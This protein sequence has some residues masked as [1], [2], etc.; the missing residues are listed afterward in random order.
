MSITFENIN[1]INYSNIATTGTQFRALNINGD[2]IGNAI[3]FALDLSETKAYRLTRGILSTVTSIKEYE[4]DAKNLIDW[5]KGGNS[6]KRQ[7]VAKAIRNDGG[8]SGNLFMVHSI[9]EMTKTDARAFM[10]DY[11]NSGGT[12]K[13]VT[14]W[15]SIAGNLLRQNQGKAPNTAGFVVNAAE[16]VVDKVE[17]T[18]DSIA[19]AIEAVVDAVINAGK[20]LVEI[21]GDVISWTVEE[22][23]GLIQALLE[24]G[25]SVG[26][27]LKAAWDFGIAGVNK[28]VK[29]LIDIGKEIGDVLVYAVSQTGEILN[30]FVGALIS[31]AVSV[32]KILE[33][34]AGQILSITSKIIQT[35]VDIGR[36][37]GTILYSAFQIGVNMVGS[38]T[39]ALI[40][41]GKTVGELLIT[42]ITQPRR[43]FNEVVRALN[44][45]GQ[46]INNLF[47]EVLG[48][49]ADGVKKMTNALIE[50][51]KSIVD[52]I[53]WA[54]NK[55][56]G[57]VKDVVK[58]IID[59]G[60][61]VLEIFTNIATR[62]TDFI[63]KVVQALFNIG[64]T[65]LKLINEVIQLGVDFTRKFILAITE[66]AGGL[67]KFAKEVLR[68]TYKA[69][70]S[71]VKKL[72]DV[73]LSVIEILGTIV[74][75]SYW[76]F[77][78]IVSGIIQHLVPVGDLLDWV[79][80]QAENTVSDLW[81]D[82]LLAIRYAKGK[83][84][85][86]IEWAV[87]KSDHTLESVL[88]AWESIEED[89]IDFYV[90]AARLA[91]SGIDRVF[92][93]IGKATIKLENSVTYVL[94]FL[95]KDFVPG[96]KDFIQGVLDAGYEITSLFVNI[97]HLSLQAFTEVI[98]A[99]LDYGITLTEL[100]TETMKNPS[101]L[102]SNFLQAVEQAGQTLNDVYQSVII[103]TGEQFIDEVTI[104]WKNLGKPV[105]DIL[106]AIAEVSTG[107]IATGISILLSTLGTYR[108]MT[109]VEIQEARLIYGNTFDY[110]RIYFSQESLLNDILFGIQDWLNENPNSRAFVTNTLVNFDVND[111]PLDFPTMIH[112][113]CHVWQF[114]DEGPFYMA[115][116]VH[117]QVW[118]AGYQYGGEAGLQ[119][120]INNNLG[121][122]IEEVFETFNPEQQ[123]SII[124]DY[125]TRRYVDSRPPEE[126]ASWQ[127]F[128]E[129]VFS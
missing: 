103:D 105:K 86:V 17:D 98:T 84:S 20:S 75:A 82:T 29:A 68:L 19:E 89:L 128:Q 81:H 120:A 104:R 39:K 113:L 7:I 55:S 37:V 38:I 22:V 1:A 16:W 4:S 112:E 24:V 36:S 72:L 92:E 73:G 85:D 54:I 25:K 109:D 108:A 69:A 67:L 28:F 3:N 15:L 51:G 70:A 32:G 8:H 46:T 48:T 9:S 44:E 96:I 101:N 40:T 100:L 10:M 62:A 78:R 129:I 6:Q 80:T 127:P 93:Q 43:L 106:I 56:A 12:T 79:L 115:E 61:S 102:L 45:I 111:G 88:N 124:Q 65:V 117:A 49:V 60:K 71:L 13:A 118:G 30:A 31:A 42:A 77:R 125:Y 33:W 34:A 21:V 107:T 23:G 91:N 114:E 14:E 76:V 64:K 95:E 126:Y 90:T 123:A 122:S 35:L 47:D 27:I 119:N 26:E 94:N 2:E 18:V 121:L 83:L 50:I 52:V 66:L 99:C 5:A 41:I 53:S 57:I 58:A 116:A 11:L 87:N 59:T 110:A 63:K 74:G 97:A